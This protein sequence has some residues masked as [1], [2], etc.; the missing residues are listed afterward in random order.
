MCIRDRIRQG[1]APANLP[2]PTYAFTADT[3]IRIG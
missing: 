2:V 1:P 3:T